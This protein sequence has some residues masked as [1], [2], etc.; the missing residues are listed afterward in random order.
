V[1]RLVELAAGLLRARGRARPRVLDPAVGDG[2]FLAAVGRRLAARLT[3]VDIDPAAVSLARG[4][5]G[6]DA[7]LV[8]ADFLADPPAVSGPFDLIIGN[9]PWGG[10]NRTLDETAKSAIRARFRTARGL[11]DPFAPFIERSTS[12]LD[13]GGIL[14][15]VLPDHF[16]LKNYPEAR[17]HVV[18]GYRLEELARWGRAFAGVNVDV[19]TLVAVRGRPV[20]RH[21][22]RCLPEGAVGRQIRIPQ[23]RFAARPGCVFNLSLDRGAAALLDRLDRRCARLDEW[24]ETHEG[25]HS[26]N[27]RARLFLPPARTAALAAR[28]QRP[29]ILGRGE[30]RPFRLTWAGRRVVYDPQAIRRDRGEYAN[31]GRERWFTSPK[32]LVRRTGDRIVAALDRKGLFA[33]NNLFVALQRPACPVPLEYVEAYLNSTLATWCFRTLQPRAGRIFAELKLV[34]LN[35]LPVPLPGNP[36]EMARIASLAERLRR[37]APARVLASAAAALDAAFLDL[38]ALAPAEG[39]RVMRE[40]RITPSASS[41]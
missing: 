18:E 19:C 27:M 32:I 34:H 9:P 21:A 11:L 16:L 41:L 37:P 5:L 39:A 23:A 2:A 7:D 6:P 8:C 30:I 35:R 12:L 28:F 20:P 15:L 1:E 14:A 29:L 17:R 33:S 31:L 38:A 13:D 10:W 3:G 40:S 4:A 25:I 24:I 26:G 22:V 36:S